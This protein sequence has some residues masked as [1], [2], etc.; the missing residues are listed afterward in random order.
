MNYLCHVLLLSF[1]VRYIMLFRFLLDV[2]GIFVSTS[3]EMYSSWIVMYVLLRSLCYHDDE[4][5]IVTVC[6]IMSC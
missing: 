4:I 1:V 2:C 6:D 3:C 5:F